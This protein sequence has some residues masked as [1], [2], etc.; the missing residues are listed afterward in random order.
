MNVEAYFELPNSLDDINVFAITGHTHHLGRDVQVGTSFDEKGP[1]TPVYAPANFSWSEPETIIH[2]PPL[3][4]TDSDGFRF[5]CEWKNTTNQP[6]G[7]GESAND[8]M[9]FFWAYYY[10]SAGAKVCVHTDQVLGGLD[11]CCP[12][13]GEETCGKLLDNL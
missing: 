3:Q 10:P 1:V 6:V 11:I 9:C 8:E 5:S 4:L 7:F 2:N 13:A 12:D